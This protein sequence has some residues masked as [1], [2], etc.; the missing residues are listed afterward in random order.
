MVNTTKIS[1]PNQPLRDLFTKT[2]TTFQSLNETKKIAVFGSIASKKHDKYSDLDLEIQ[3]NN[4]N[5][6]SKNFKK[7]VSSIASPFVI[8]PAVNEPG[9]GIF[10][11]IWRGFSF[12]QR[13]DLRIF[14]ES[15]Q[16][17]SGSQVIYISNKKRQSSRKLKPLNTII[18]MSFDENLRPFYDFY[19]G[20]T[21]YV[22]HS[23]RK[24][25]LS[26]FKFYRSALD[27]FIN[28]HFF[29]SQAKKFVNSTPG[30]IEFASLDRSI[31]NSEKHPITQYLY[32]K[33]H[34]GMDKNYIKLTE[35]Y[36]K[37]CRAINLISQESKE[38]EF[39]KAVIEFMHNELGRKRSSKNSRTN[40]NSRRHK[41]LRRV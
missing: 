30:V 23:K 26:S 41:E 8:F 37:L 6:F 29:S 16:L 25:H 2:I 33:N 13:L 14:D 32:I 31:K 27:S 18:K 34:L 28:L 4:Y 35:N 3:T 24:E 36:L 40:R 9:N 11:I 17:S 7:I 38:E 12:Y 19:I 15:K 20:A 5:F 10:T 39:S 21:R 22:K 1:L